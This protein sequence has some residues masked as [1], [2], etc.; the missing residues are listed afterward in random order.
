MT[1]KHITAKPKEPRR[2]LPAHLRKEVLIESGYR[3]ANPTC[4]FPLI[5][6]HHIVYVQHGGENTLGNLIALCGNC[7]PMVHNGTIR[8]EAIRVWKKMI[9]AANEAWSK[10]TLNNLLFLDSPIGKQLYLTGDGVVRFSDL[11]VSG[12]A[13]AELVNFVNIGGEKADQPIIYE[14]PLNYPFAVAGSELAKTAYVVKLSEKGQ[15][16]VEAWK[17]GSL[18]KLDAAFINNEPG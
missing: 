4:N 3:C 9:V 16:L 6:V 14:V 18:K 13:Y 10:D 2:T 7:H 17:E 12:L 5:H 8:E 15:R 11:L 1:K